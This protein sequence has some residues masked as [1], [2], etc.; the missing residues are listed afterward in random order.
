MPA[1]EQRSPE[2]HEEFS[3]AR[4]TTTTKP[5]NSAASEDVYVEDISSRDSGYDGDIEVVKPYAIEEPEDEAPSHVP[6]L[7][8]SPAPNDAESWQ[9]ELVDSM[10]DLHC[11]SDHPDLRCRPSHKRGRKRKTPTVGAGNSAPGRR[12]VYKAAPDIQYEG[13]SASPKRLRR[14]SR[15]P[16]EGQRTPLSP[17]SSTE[18]DSPASLSLS[19]QSTDASGAS[20]STKP[21][22]S[23]EMDI[24]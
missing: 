7:A 2:N 4:S 12:Q 17:R 14:R 19:P 1:D 8:I 6:R 20:P 18:T 21:N 5:S 15:R 10:Q 24:D 22:V 13:P 23:D 3:H 11:D 16:K 9:G